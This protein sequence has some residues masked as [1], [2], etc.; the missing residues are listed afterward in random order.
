MDT[1]TQITMDLGRKCA[2]DVSAAMRRTILLADDR[3]GAMAIAA[4][5]AAQA[6]GALSGSVAAFMDHDGGMTPDFIDMIW[7]DILR[8]VALGELLEGAST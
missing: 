2:D 6:L 7:K 5:G 3:S 4:Y 1:T 8:P